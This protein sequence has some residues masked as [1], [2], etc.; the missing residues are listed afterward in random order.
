[1]SSAS[2]LLR[3]PVSL[4]LGVVRTTGG[5]VV[6]VCT[7]DGEDAT[8]GANGLVAVAAPAAAGAPNISATAASRAPALAIP[9]RATIAP[10]RAAA[11]SRGSPGARDRAA[12]PRRP[13][14]GRRS[15]R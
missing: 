1:M 14:R 2:P 12:P 9:A 5:A 3:P 11:P 8:P 6:V 15:R 7:C 10:T 13:P 4:V